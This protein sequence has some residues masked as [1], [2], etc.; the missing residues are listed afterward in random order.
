LKLQRMA[1]ERGLIKL[2]HLNST[3]ENSNI[4]GSVLQG[5]HTLYIELYLPIEALTSR[6]TFV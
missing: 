3:G 2:L 5:H 4:T 1:M 6:Y